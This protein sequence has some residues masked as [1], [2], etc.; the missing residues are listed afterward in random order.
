MNIEQRYLLRITCP[1]RTGLVVAIMRH[2]A[3]Q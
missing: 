3:D 1:G 2:S